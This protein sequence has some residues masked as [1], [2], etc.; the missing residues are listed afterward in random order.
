M[1]LKDLLET[2]QEVA[3]TNN[4]STPYIVGGLPRDILLE[5]IDD[6][7]DIDIT[8]GSKDVDIL[9]EMFA[10]ALGAKVKDMDDHKQV[11]VGDI[12]FD[13][14]SNFVHDNIEDFGVTGS[15]LQKET[16][17]R[18]FTINS[19][20][21]PLDF[22]TVLDPTGKGK[23]DLAK[24]ILDCPIDCNVSFAASPNRML[25]AFYYKAKY[26]L[27]FS[28]NVLS[29]IKNNLDLLKTIKTRYASDLINKIVRYKPEII[30]ELIELGV[31]QKLPLTKYLTKVLLQKRKILDII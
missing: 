10:E 11:I 27:H 29:A 28:D 7:H 2:M 16:Y 1:A 25:R 14:S 22:S 23:A 24:G 5:R 19:L 3:K 8:T 18:D 30:E 31:L 6:I 4:L 13:F 15:N 20:L 9:A 17:S 12:T 26:N 21:V